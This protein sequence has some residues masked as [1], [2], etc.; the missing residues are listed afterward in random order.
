MSSRA[1]ATRRRVLASARQCVAEL[2][3]LGATS[4]EIARRAGVS[5]GVIQYHFGTREGILLAMIED[6]LD[7]L[8]DA[9]DSLDGHAVPA[10]GERL[11]V[12]VDA[13]WQYCTQPDYLLYTDVLRLLSRDPDSTGAVLVML[14]RAEQQLTRRINR[15]LEDIIDSDAAVASTRGLI[16][17]AMRGLALRTSMTGTPTNAAPVGAAERD[18]LVRGLTLALTPPD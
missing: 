3:P 6:G 8:L 13:I 7:G 1:L 11:Q 2:G 14:Q 12:V 18:L 10:L 16:F 9:L 5:W 17:A 4:N 15:I